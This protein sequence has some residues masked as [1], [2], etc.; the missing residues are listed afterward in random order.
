[1]F[2]SVNW[3]LSAMGW[4]FAAL[5]LCALPLHAQKSPLPLGTINPGTIRRLQS[6]PVGYYGGMSCFRGRVENCPN[7]ATIGFI[8]GVE[9]PGGSI[10]GT[11]VFLV[12]GGGEN[13]YQNSDFARA[14]LQQGFQI[15]YFTW[16]SDW[17]A[18]DGNNG[19]SIK[20]AACRPATFLNFVDQNLHSQGPMCAQALSAGSGAAAYALAWYG[21]GSYLDNVE[22]LSGPVFGDIEQGC[23]V[24]NPPKLTVCDFGQ[25]GCEGDSWLDPPSYVNGDPGLV[26]RWSGQPSCNNS[27]NKDTS[28]LANALWKQMSI[29]DGTDNPSFDY[30]HTSMAAWLCSS[31]DSQQNNSAAEGEYFYQQFTSFGQTAGYSVTRIDHCNGPED[32]SAGTTPQGQSGLTAISN[33]MLAA[34]INR[35]VGKHR[36]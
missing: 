19:A 27:Q 13:A 15:I 3:L 4:V 8:Y 16:D 21:A 36:Q 14:Y 18:T 17:E 30:P 12:G 9:D 23:V 6:C 31:E 29:V 1:M 33:H 34:C 5:M 11:V 28:Q 20:A 26:G 2:R 35:H 7:T 10:A 22:M 25:L 32:V 24:P